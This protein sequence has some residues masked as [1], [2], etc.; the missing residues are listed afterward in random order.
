[1]ISRTFKKI[2]NI[3]RPVNRAK[4]LEGQQEQEILQLIKELEVNIRGVQ[5]KLAETTAALKNHPADDPKV[6]RSFLA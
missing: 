3:F 6:E 5:G 1:M 2:L 4:E